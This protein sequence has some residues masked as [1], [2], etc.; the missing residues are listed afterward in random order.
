MLYV[1]ITNIEL[2]DPEASQDP[3]VPS[4]SLIKCSVV[5][6]YV[7]SRDQIGSNSI[8]DKIYSLTRYRTLDN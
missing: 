1:N 6:K 7:G 2:V 5:V 4:E 8:F 3:E